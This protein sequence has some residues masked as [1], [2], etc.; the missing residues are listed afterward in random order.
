MGSGF[1]GVHEAKA[2][3][4]VPGVIVMISI[5][6]DFRQFPAKKIVFKAVL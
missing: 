3:F 4:W 6:D 1:I 2:F 5:L